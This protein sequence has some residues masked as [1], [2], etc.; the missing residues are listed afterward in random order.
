MSINKNRARY[1]KAQNG[2]QWK[3]YLINE[4]YPSYWDEMIT[5]RKG[6]FSHKYRSYKSWKYNRKTQYKMKKELDSL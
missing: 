2:R 6:N 1:N 3:N 4:L 5:F